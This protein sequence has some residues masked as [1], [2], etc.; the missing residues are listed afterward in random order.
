VTTEKPVQVYQIFIKAPPERVWQ[1]LTL[2]EFT[3]RY[4]HGSAFET[5]WRPGS[6]YRSM[7]GDVV[8]VEGRVLEYDP[9]RRLVYT[10]RALWDPEVTKDKESRVTCELEDAGGGMTRL[11]LVHDE[12]EGETETYKQ[13]AGGWMWVLSNLKTLLETG[14]TLPAPSQGA[15]A[16]T[17]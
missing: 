1:G 2:P 14:D 17:R 12:F 15:A 9:P 11:T 16:S 8:M 13:T 6:T 3:Q 10:W 4:F 5:D 7:A